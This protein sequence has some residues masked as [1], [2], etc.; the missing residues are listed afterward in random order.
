MAS[1][2]NIFLTAAFLLAVILFFGW[3]PSADVWVQNHFYNPQSGHWLIVEGENPWLDF[4]LYDGMK[5]LLIIVYSILLLIVLL[6]YRKKWV[7][8]H[9]R[10]MIILVLSGILVPSVVVGLKTLTNVPCPRDW[11]MY[12]GEYPHV[13]VLDAYPENF[14][15]EHRIRCWPAGHA[16]FGFSLLALVFVFRRKKEQMLALIGAMGIAWSMG[17]YKI[18]KGDHFLSHTIIAMIMGWLI[19]LLIVRLIDFLQRGRRVQ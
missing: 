4:I 6:G 17:I 3:N 11:Q 1:T 5:K 18:L 13:G 2:K 12:G 19:I 9:R 14:C 10:A 16:S 8:H 15:Q 7:Q